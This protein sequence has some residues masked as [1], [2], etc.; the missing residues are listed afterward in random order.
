[1]RSAVF[2]GSF[3]N[4]SMVVFRN[5]SKGAFCNRPT[6]Q[7]KWTATRADLAFGSNSQLRALAEVYACSDAKEKFVHDF[8][9]A[10]HKVMIL[11]R[12]DVQ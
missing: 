7:V 2:K 8:V 1:M 9:G 3:G 6:H 10:W 12:F 4:R 5:A 11:D